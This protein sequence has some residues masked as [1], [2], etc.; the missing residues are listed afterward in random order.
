M[1]GI[2]IHYV[3]RT[4]EVKLPQRYAIYHLLQKSGSLVQVQYSLPEYQSVISLE[5]LWKPKDDCELQ[6]RINI[7]FSRPCVYF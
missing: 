2:N 7:R 3:K 5:V 6:A 1:L 4:P